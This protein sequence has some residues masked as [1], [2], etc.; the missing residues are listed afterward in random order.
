MKVMTVA[1]AGRAQLQRSGFAALAV[2][3][4]LF[5]LPDYGA[6]A[7]DGTDPAIGAWQEHSY[8]FEFVGYYSAYDCDGLAE[9]LRLLIQAAGARADIGIS[10]ACRDPGRL[11]GGAAV[12]LIFHA[13][14]PASA[15]GPGSIPVRWRHVTI[16]EQRPLQISSADCELVEQFV[17]QLLPRF[18]VQNLENHTRCDPGVESPGA[19]HVAFDALAPAN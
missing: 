1:G 16:R 4:A 12:N 18:T 5:A 8:R 19:V 15:G 6:S 14:E 3:L 7:P 13:L 11:A 10:D 2:A 9:K 17:D